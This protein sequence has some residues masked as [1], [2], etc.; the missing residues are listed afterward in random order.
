M[1][2]YANRSMNSFFWLFRFIVICYLWIKTYIVR[3]RLHSVRLSLFSLWDKNISVKIATRL[4]NVM[5]RALIDRT[6]RYDTLWNYL[7]QWGIDKKVIFYLP[8]S[9]CFLSFWYM[10][11]P[12]TSYIYTAFKLWFRDTFLS[13]KLLFLL[14]V[15]YCWYV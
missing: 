1:Q 15:N 8:L 9:L 14:Y 13:K 4:F 2:L 12:D 5:I 3:P 11:Q 6:F 10:L 7:L